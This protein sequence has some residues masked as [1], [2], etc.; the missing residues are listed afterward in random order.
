MLAG[1]ITNDKLVNDS[2]IIGATEVDLGT[3]VTA[4]TGLTSLTS[5]VLL[6][7]LGAP[8]TR[9]DIYASAISATGIVTAPTFAGNLSA[10][11]TST[12][13]AAVFSGNAVF[14][15]GLSVASGQTATIN[16]DLDVNGTTTFADITV[17]GTF[18]AESTANFNTDFIKLNALG[19]VQN[20]GITIERG[21]TDVSFFWDESNDKW[22]IASETLVAGMVESDVTG[23]HYGDV[24]IA[25]GETIDVSAGTITF[26]NDQ[27]SGNAINGGTI[28]SITITTLAS[29]TV[30][31]D[32]GS[33]DGVS[34]GNA[35]RGTGKFSTLDATGA[36]TTDTN[37]TATGSINGA[38][39]VAT[40]SMTAPLFTGDL[41]GDADGDHTGT[42]TGTM[43]GAIGGASDRSTAHFSTVDASNATLSSADINGG[44]ID[45]VVIGGASPNLITGTTISGTTINASTF[46]GNITGD[47]T[48]D[49][50]GNVTIPVGD[51]L[52]VNGT[53][54]IDNMTVNQNLTVTGDMT[55]NGTTTSLNTEEIKLADNYILL[56]SGTSTAQNAGLEVDLSGGTTKS[57]E[58]TTS[59]GGRWSVGSEDFAA[60]N[61][62]GDVTGDV[63][64]N[65]TGNI[66]STGTS[67]FTTIDVNGGNIDGTIIGGTSRAE[68]TGTTIT[69]DTRFYGPL[70]GDV[71]GD[72]VGD[73][74]GTVS[75]ITNHSTTDLSEGS[76]L[77]YTDARARASVSVTDTGGDGGLTY[78]S[79]S[80]VFTYTGPSA[81]E[82]RAHITGSTG[83]TFSGGA[84]SIGQPVGTTD[85][86]TFNDVDVD[87][88]LTVAGSLSFGTVEI[89]NSLT[90]SGNI[91]S[92]ESEQ[93]A[94]SDNF[95]LLNAV[96]SGSTPHAGETAG[97]EI[98]RGTNSNKF[99]SWDETADKWSLG[100]ETL[101]AGTVEA[102]FTGTLTG[103]VNH[104]SGTSNFQN[105]DATGTIEA[106]GV[107][108]G[109]AGFSG[110]LTGNVSGTVNDI[111]NHSTTALSEGTNL[112][113]TTARVNNHLLSNIINNVMPAAGTGGTLD[114]GTNGLRWRDGY[115][116]RDVVADSLTAVTKNFV[117]DH[118]TKEDHKLRYAS[119]EGPENGVYVRGKLKGEN[120]I[121]L[122]DYWTALVHEES[123]TVNLTANL[124]FQ[125]LYVEKIEDG[126][127]Y[128]NIAGADIDAIDC[129]YTVYGERKDVDRLE[130]EFKKDSE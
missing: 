65:V 76:N 117:I 57:L 99:F 93:I 107:I 71:T 52:T 73:V 110:D 61:F 66:T 121:E 98:D 64:G 2:V 24:T 16:G 25:G 69:A 79:T 33:I 59:S 11:G 83:V 62:I 122:P 13:G 47:V 78:N 20:A 43:S 35:S 27:I 128:I 89:T 106:D 53:F 22:S 45:G 3:T 19:T 82:V 50:T 28:D 26:A 17:P 85:N 18:T 123:I 42:F 80:G 60:A 1:S 9:N 37:V 105:I 70:T 58:W 10:T 104:A 81:S 111:S 108:T 7:E 130:I 87:G 97:I 49:V 101:V 23:H 115:F 124:G 96:P 15:A 84:I 113:F 54:A 14:N 120:V 92:L 67:T 46:N 29:S 31:I 86:V 77:Y 38:T 102:D 74:T 127:V 41:T 68:I 55:V 8:A 118:P 129:F 91:T 100:G 40:T 95:I 36:I 119:L 30:N 51:T 88:D 32:G 90:V 75:S 48:G 4:F 63:T 94:F 125:Q 126:K 12:L 39:V 116:T 6:G 112:Y 44:T 21:A 103:R 109:N 114:L 56:N 5:T 34:I 72:I